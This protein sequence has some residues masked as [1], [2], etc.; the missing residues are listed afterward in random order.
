M[1]TDE[2][3]DRSIQSLTAKIDNITKTL[4]ASGDYNAVMGRLAA[5]KQMELLSVQKS[6][7]LKQKEILET[8]K[9]V[10]A[11]K[12]S[13]ARENQRITNAKAII[14]QDNAVKNQNI[15]LIAA[16]KL[17]SSNIEESLAAATQEKIAREN[18]LSELQKER[19]S[20]R[21]SLEVNQ[22]MAASY[23]S[24]I[25]EGQTLTEAE[26]NNFENFQAISTELQSKLKQVSDEYAKE[27]IARQDLIGNTIKMA[28]KLSEAQTEMNKL[29]TENGYLTTNIG[30]AKKVL[31]DATEELK[32]NEEEQKKYG[33]ALEGATNELNNFKSQQEALSSGGGIK[34]FLQ[35]MSSLGS[36]LESAG[37]TMLGMVDKAYAIQKEL[38]TTIGTAGKI[39]VDA[40][41][42]V[43]A[44]LKGGGP[45]L[46]FQDTID[47]VNAYQKEFGTILT[48]DSAKTF[49][50]A[51]KKFGV[52]FGT[53][54]KALRS[55]SIAGLQSA[56]MQQKVIN[57]FVSAGLTG[58]Q[59]LEFAA[60]NANLVAIAGYKYADSLAKAAIHATKIGVS[61]GKTEDFADG[62]IDD[63]EGGIEKFAELQSLGFDVDVNKMME[64]AATG[65]PGAPQA[66]LERQLSANRSVIENMSR[67]Q[68]RQLE[69][70]LTGLGIADI[71][72][73]AGIALTP[74]EQGQV[75]TQKEES[76]ESKTSQGI[77]S[78][79]KIIS[80]VGWASLISGMTIKIGENIAALVKN[81]YALM[82]FLGKGILDVGKGLFQGGKWLM[83]KFAGR[84]AATA[85]EGAAIEGGAAATAAEGAAGVGVLNTIG[86]AIP[87]GG[88]LTMGSAAGFGGAAIGAATVGTILA[89]L[90]AGLFIG[91]K[92]NTSVAKGGSGNLGDVWNYGFGKSKQEK[93]A[94][95][96]Q[97][98]FARSKGYKDWNAYSQAK[99]ER[100][101]TMPIP[102]PV[103]PGTPIETS[104]SALSRKTDEGRTPIVPKI[105][106]TKLEAKLDSVV[107]SIRNMKAQ[108]QINGHDLG[109]V[110]LGERAPLGFPSPGRVIG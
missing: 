68:R 86:A 77:E 92:F 5:T 82:A 95:T 32:K 31:A 21:S 104:P 38:G 60:E 100:M 59:A 62:L 50:Q 84:T 74:E 85:I 55:F 29:K 49:A 36:K 17:Q 94:I 54:G 110:T 34:G 81:T 72:K 90:G 40:V 83:N 44:S 97:D 19:D 15:R 75:K 102:T 66:E 3:L 106:T 69:K 105:D 46:T 109:M 42:N 89:G 14:E 108:I 30:D 93:E 67:F 71:K 1:A 4:G 101:A 107:N 61:L 45:V 13:T 51:A 57:Q 103:T 98:E 25:N 78:A 16:L 65:V 12:E 58:K 52:D 56:Q 53:Y 79:L 70:S 48:G 26:R 10:N 35:G 2:E 7:A 24:R 73:L 28:S 64:A 39:S 6:I 96:K 80:A 20:L 47:A 99:K 76:P 91:D 22:R 41:K 11:L 87:I 63:F 23:Q 88:G 27:S 8:L 9:K 18:T 43:A 33:Q 37:R